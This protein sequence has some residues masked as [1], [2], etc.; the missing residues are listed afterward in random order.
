MVLQVG[1]ADRRHGSNEQTSGF[2]MK[3]EAL[4]SGSQC[5][6]GKER[7][8]LG[9]SPYEQLKFAGFQKMSAGQ[10]LSVP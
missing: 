6:T 8:S 5:L 3:G 1:W 9:Q 10:K 2:A 4:P 7:T